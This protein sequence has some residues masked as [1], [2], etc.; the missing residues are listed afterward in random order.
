M[1][2]YHLYWCNESQFGQLFPR[3]SRQLVEEFYKIPD[4]YTH[5]TPEYVQ[6]SGMLSFAEK[7]MQ[8]IAWRMD[9]SVELTPHYWKNWLGNA[10][11]QC[12]DIGCGNGELLQVLRGLGHE[13]VGVEFDEDAKKVAEHSEVTI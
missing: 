3:P 4:Y 2:P 7:A 13:V 8:H 9:Y 11:K 5:H 12:C 6:D 1:D 10:Q